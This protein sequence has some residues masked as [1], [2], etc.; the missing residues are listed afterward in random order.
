MFTADDLPD[1][2]R[3]AYFDWYNNDLPRWLQ[4]KVTARVESDMIQYN[5]LNRQTV[6]KYAHLDIVWVLE[7]WLKLNPVLHARGNER[8]VEI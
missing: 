5:K 4:E 3:E 2:A 6:V 8:V 1:D 7:I